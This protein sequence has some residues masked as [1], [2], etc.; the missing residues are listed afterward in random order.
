[1]LVLLDAAS[2][3]YRSYYALPESLTAP[4]GHPNNMLRGFLSTVTK[5]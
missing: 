3:Y 2:L 4:D 1:V 5:L